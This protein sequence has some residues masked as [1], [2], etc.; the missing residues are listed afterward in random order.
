MSWPVTT[1][2]NML[3]GQPFTH[4][5]V[6]T[7][8]PGTTGANEVSGGAPAYARQAIVVNTSSGG[9]RALNAAAVADVPACTVRF[10]GYWNGSTFVGY[11]A[12]GGATPKNFVA[13]PA[14]D[15][16]ILPSHGWS[17]GQKIVFVYGTAPGGLSAGTVYFVRDQ[18]T[19]S[20]KV[21]ATLGGVAMNISSG[22]SVG[23]F[24]VAITETVYASQDTHTL[25]S[26]NV[27]FPD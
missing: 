23:C 18:S 25:A 14:T 19:D 2:D 8:Y 27:V 24:V 21:A 1:K 13:T 11:A 12:N 6:H 22:A 10:F 7:G 4:M 26:T 9:I 20:F 5:S 15:L 3:N 17:D 16:I